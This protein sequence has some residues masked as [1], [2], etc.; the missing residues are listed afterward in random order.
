MKITNRLSVFSN[1]YHIIRVATERE[2]K[3]G[4]R[5]TKPHPSNGDRREGVQRS[6]QSS[7]LVLPQQTKKRQPANRGSER[8]FGTITFQKAVPGTLLNMKSVGWSYGILI[9]NS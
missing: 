8:Y 5:A 1:Y 7:P 3:K 9:V 2:R 6:E 4:R